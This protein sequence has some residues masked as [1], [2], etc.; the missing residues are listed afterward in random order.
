MTTAAHD[1]HAAHADH[2]RH[3][4]DISHV[5]FNGS[6]LHVEPSLLELMRLT[7]FLVTFI[8]TAKKWFC[9]KASSFSNVCCCDSA[10]LL[11]GSV[12]VI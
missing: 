5:S 11:E 7:L 8:R 2:Q 12:S 3:V 4:S 10:R 6:S 1:A 9:L